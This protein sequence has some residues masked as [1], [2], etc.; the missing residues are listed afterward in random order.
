MNFVVLL[1]DKSSQIF[2]KADFYG[3]VLPL[4]TAMWVSVDNKKVVEVVDNTPTTLYCRYF[5]KKM[6]NDEF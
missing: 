6:M 4:Y 1:K 2:P 3:S 5:L